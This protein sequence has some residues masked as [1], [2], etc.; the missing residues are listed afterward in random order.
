M[1]FFSLKPHPTPIHVTLKR[2]LIRML[3]HVHFEVTGGEESTQAD[4]TNKVLLIILFQHVQIVETFVAESLAT[5][6]TLITLLRVHEDNVRPKEVHFAEIF[7]AMR[8]GLG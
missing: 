5:S 6:W 3:L 7:I 8:T 4:V 1:I 2:F